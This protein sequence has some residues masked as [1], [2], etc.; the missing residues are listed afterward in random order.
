MT[1]QAD[2]SK[3]YEKFA[4]YYDQYTSGFSEDLPFY[5]SLCGRNDRILEIGCGSGRVLK[6]FLE[7]G[8]NITGIDTSAQML[9]MAGSKLQEFIDKGRLKLMLHDFREKPLDEVFDAALITW[10][11]F[12]YILERKD[13][14]IFLKN[15]HHSLKDGGVISLDLFYPATFAKPALENIWTEKSIT[16]GFSL[17]DRR[18]VENNI[19]ERTQVFSKD[20]AGEEIVTHRKFIDKIEMNE[21]LL[22]AGFKDIKFADHYD[23]KNLHDPGTDE[24]TSSNFIVKAVK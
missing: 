9:S 20:G 6:A 16:G 8:F 11:T 17:K 10:Y 7:K 4:K 15:T 22:N 3:T 19:E 13:R 12:N 5:L 18:K 21:L 1:D 23:F 14:E 24:K 2:S